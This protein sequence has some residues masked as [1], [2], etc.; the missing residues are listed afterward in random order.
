[1]SL[2]KEKEELLSMAAEADETFPTINQQEDSYYIEYNDSKHYN[3][4]LSEFN[5]DYSIIRN[6]ISMLW[7][8]TNKQY[9]STICSAVYKTKENEDSILE[10]IDLYN[11]MM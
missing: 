9:V 2:T 5:S 7:S 11:Y 10:A 1:M 8:D 6:N 4:V 3:G